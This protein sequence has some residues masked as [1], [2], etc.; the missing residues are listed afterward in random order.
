MFRGGVRARR[1]NIQFVQYK[2]KTS[3]MKSP[4]KDS[5]PDMWTNV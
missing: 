4:H 5:K 3:Y 1:E 2:K